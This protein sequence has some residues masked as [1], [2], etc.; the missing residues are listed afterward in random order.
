M[1]GHLVVNH[2]ICTGCKTCTLACS[3]SHHQICNPALSR[4]HIMKWPEDGLD[5]P[6]VCRQ[7]AK[8]PCAKACPVE[9]I[10]RNPQTGAWLVDPERCIGCRDCLQACPFGA[11]SL[12]PETQEVLK[13]DL[14]GGEPQCARFCEIGALKFVPASKIGYEHRRQRA[15]NSSKLKANSA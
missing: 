6:V 7:C 5:I 8:A 15:L 13:C 4:V 3:L 10:V 2:A 14:C 1:H 11:I 9:A 12:H